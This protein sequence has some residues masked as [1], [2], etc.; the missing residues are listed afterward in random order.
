MHEAEQLRKIID[1]NKE[2][3]LII[4]KLKE[5]VNKGKDDI[6]K[7]VKRKDTHIEMLKANVEKLST[8]HDEMKKL[9]DKQA[10][11]LEDKAKENKLLESKLYEVKNNK[12][13]LSKDINKLQFQTKSSIKHNIP[14]KHISH[15]TEAIDEYTIF[16]EMRRAESNSHSE[17]ICSESSIILYLNDNLNSSFV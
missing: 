4:K 3:K 14:K 6:S 16:K 1:E 7:V 10:K 15:S 13:L 9:C 8:E 11:E 5:Q 17:P 2:L 12:L